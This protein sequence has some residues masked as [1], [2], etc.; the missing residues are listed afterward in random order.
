MIRKPNM[1]K[2]YEKVKLK[3]LSEYEKI[4]LKAKIIL[5]YKQY[6]PS[7]RKVAEKYNVSKSTAHSWIV[8]DNNAKDLTFKRKEYKKREHPAKKEVMTCLNQTLQTRPFIT[9]S[10]MSSLLK[11]K[12]GVT[13]SDRTV[14]RYS[15]EAGYTVKKAGVIVNH[16]H[17]NV[18]VQSFCERFI[19]AY[20]D[21]NLYCIDE[22][23]F[24][25][26]DHPRKGRSKRG[27]RLA[28][29]NTTTLRK[30]KFS[31]GMA[32]SP[33][34][35][36]ATQVMTHNF[37]KPDFVRFFNEINLP[38]GAVILMDNLK[39][40]HSVVVKEVLET[41]GFTPLYTPPYSPRCNPIEKVFGKIKP[42]YRHK[43]SELK[44]SNKDDFS[45][46]FAKII[47]E[48]KLTS[49]DPTFKNTLKFIKE[50]LSNIETD[51]NFQ[52]HGYD[53]SSFIRL[54]QEDSL[55]INVVAG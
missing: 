8:K 55:S 27:T 15:S 3:E 11:E 22:A 14:N 31:F 49:F 26:G 13:L 50:T 40:H 7:I 19:S 9:M 35:I 32:I 12:C 53:V 36:I 51:P 47:E 52:F 34:G 24:Y 20:K 28:V 30:T 42:L 43:C 45:N 48:H 16:K 37:K 5:D 18:Q 38:N 44:S 46:V 1:E 33:K 54:H 41:R 6:I 4:M 25:V 17:N 39:A 2:Q 23:G 29:A 21:D 10:E